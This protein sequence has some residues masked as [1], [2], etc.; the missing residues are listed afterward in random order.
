MK[1]FLLTLLLITLNSTS[2]AAEEAKELPP[3]DPSYMGEHHMVLVNHS[4]TIYASVMTTYNR[5]SNVQLLYKIENKDLALL[6]TVRDGHL[7]TIKTKPFNLQRLM[8]GEKM[9]ILAD[10]YA[11]HFDRG[12]MLVYENI[13]L[14]FA[15]MLYVREFDDIKDSNNQQEYDVVNLKKSYKIYIH[16]IQKAPSF[17]HLLHIDIEAGCLTRFRTSSAV[18][19]ETELQFKFWNCGTM[20]PLYFETQDFEKVNA[21]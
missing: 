7:T 10:L 16:K 20:K 19:K 15:K 14:T 5:P 2:Y 12:G 11:G 9:E 3:L 6:Q 17:A 4:S 1:K 18:P 8:R 13:P 21:P